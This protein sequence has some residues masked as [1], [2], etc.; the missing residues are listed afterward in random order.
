MRKLENLHFHFHVLS[1]LG[2]SQGPKSGTKLVSNK[3]LYNYSS[4]KKLKHF[5]QYF[6]KSKKLDPIVFLDLARKSSGVY[7]HARAQIDIIK[8][9]LLTY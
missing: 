1:G 3:V 5:A 2:T 4:I 6:K 9:L 8:C 7:F